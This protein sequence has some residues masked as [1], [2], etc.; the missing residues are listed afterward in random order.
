ME[1]YCVAP[2]LLF[3]FP[4]VLFV[5]SRS[6]IKVFILLYCVVLAYIMI[7]LAAE[8]LMWCVNSVLQSSLGFG[9]HIANAISNYTLCFVSSGNLATEET[10]KDIFQQ[11]L[12]LPFSF[13]FLSFPRLV[14][15]LLRILN[16]LGMFKPVCSY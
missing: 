12:S 2:C 8:R 11:F 10:K 9:N 14:T 1:L 6:W 16:I 15:V 3:I 4:T 5:V 13:T 7:K